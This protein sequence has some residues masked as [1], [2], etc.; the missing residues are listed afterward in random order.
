MNKSILHAERLEYRSL[1][2]SIPSILLTVLVLSV[3]SMNLLANKELF[4]TD[5]IALDCGFT[6]SWIPLLIM[7]AIC[8]AYGGK[9]AVRISILSIAINLA[10][11]AIFKLVSLTPGMWGAY[12]ESGDEAVN[13]ALNATIGGSSWIV[14]GSAVAMTASSLTN[15]ALNMCVAKFLRKDNFGAFALRSFPSTFIAQ[16]VDNL[17]FCLLVSVPLFGWK[18]KQV[19]ICSITAAAFELGMEV[20]FSRMGY[21]LSLFMKDRQAESHGTE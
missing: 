18:F 17:T 11:F 21:K 15:S 12:Y 14:I 6:L 13:S 9:A 2:K 7:D 19:L 20:L 3:V 4:R 5:W 10:V 8:R 1:L 16:F